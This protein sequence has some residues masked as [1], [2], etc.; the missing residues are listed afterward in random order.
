MKSQQ[1]Q[2]LKVTENDVLERE[3]LGTKTKFWVSLQEGETD[4][5][6][7]FKIPRAHTGEHWAEKVAFEVA[8]LL[9]IECADI[10]LARFRET[11]GSCS[12]S[13][14]NREKKPEMIH[15]NEIMAGKFADYEKEKNTIKKI[16]RWIILLQQSGI[17]AQSPNQKEHS[18]I[19]PDI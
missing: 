14:I 3:H 7:L 15:G 10:Q 6:W 18:K 13:F 12:K 5:E 19:L 4:Q 9:D 1:Y 16:I 8:C 2:V 11:L 17:Q